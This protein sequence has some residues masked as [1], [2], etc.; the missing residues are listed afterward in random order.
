[1]RQPATRIDTRLS[2]P[3][4]ARPASSAGRGAGRPV[5]MLSRWAAG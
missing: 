2:D 1:M 4:S 3:G 5:M